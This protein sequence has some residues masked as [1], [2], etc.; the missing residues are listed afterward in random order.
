MG[1]PNTGEPFGMPMGTVRGILALTSM[2]LIVWG[3]VTRSPDLLAIL[4]FGGPYI[5]FYFGKRSGDSP[6]TPV[7]AVAAPYIPGDGAGDVTQ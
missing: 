3:F 5:G 6:A 7:E 1:L 2:A 4:A